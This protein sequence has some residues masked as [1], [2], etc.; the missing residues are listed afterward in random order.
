[1][2]HKEGVCHIPED[3]KPD[4]RRAILKSRIPQLGGRGTHKHR[5]LHLR[6]TVASPVDVAPSAVE[7]LLI[8]SVCVGWLI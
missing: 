2:N 8:S 4:Y 5:C 7:Q 1:M 6:R 3:G